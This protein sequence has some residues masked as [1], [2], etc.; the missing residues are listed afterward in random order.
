MSSL[1]GPSLPVFN[2][3]PGA[4]QTLQDQIE[5][6]NASVS[7]LS[8]QLN[9]IP[10]DSGL[11]HTYTPKKHVTYMA[12]GNQ[13][14]EE[15]NGAYM[16]MGTDQPGHAG[17]GQ[18]AQGASKSSTIDM[19]VGRG[20]SLN[21]GEGPGEGWFVGN[22]FSADAARI[23]VSESTNIDKNFGIAEVPRD[24][25]SGQNDHP[26]SG[27]GIKAD[28]VR[29]IARNS[30]KICTGRNQGFT[31]QK[32]GKER[33]SLGGLSSQAGTISLIGGNYSGQE[34]KYLG[35][36]DPDGAFKGINYLQP[37]IK[38]DNLV[39]CLN[40]L[41]KYVDLVA[42]A[43]MNGMLG[44]MGIDVGFITDPNTS[45]PQKLKIIQE[46]GLRVPYGIQFI[47]EART[48]GLEDRK[49]FLQYGGEMHIRSQNVY[50]T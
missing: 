36:H 30:I 40:A 29:M 17:T 11:M 43:T 32:G 48:T 46:A 9:E 23:Y 25:A 24:P 34:M 45:F 35:L 33:N 39:H 7:S 49:A 20:S 26:L 1:S 47:H 13:A 3:P 16:V 50:L 37:A 38:G 10:A 2:A 8:D 22:M 5:Q 6:L 27:I 42:S 12:S 15:H 31:G 44:Q 41:Y 21:D 28:N 19:V 14:V 4:S 18:G